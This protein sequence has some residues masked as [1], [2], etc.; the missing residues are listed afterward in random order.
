MSSAKNTY[1]LKD[2]LDFV[3]LDKIKILEKKSLSKSDKETLRLCKTQLKKDWRTPLI[4][5]LDM[6]L[7]K[8]KSC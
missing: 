2:E 7:R 8:Y 4:R 1:V 6:M 3:I 5:Q